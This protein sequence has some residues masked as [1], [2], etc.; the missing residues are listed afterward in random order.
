M[1]NLAFSMQRTAAQPENSTKPVLCLRA[2][3]IVLI[4]LSR[5]G[6]RVIAKVTLQL[7]LRSAASMRVSQC[8]GRKRGSRT[9]T[10]VKDGNGGQ[11]RKPGSRTAPQ[12][13]RG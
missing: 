2:P 12:L 9:E 5:E 11:G 13:R 8:Q 3:D 7:R 1:E 10:G 4:L 6:R